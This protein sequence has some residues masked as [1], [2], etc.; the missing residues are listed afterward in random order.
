MQ[1]PGREAHGHQAGSP[2]AGHLH[3]AEDL[4]VPGEGFVLQRREVGG[5]VRVQSRRSVALQP[6]WRV[7]GLALSATWKEAV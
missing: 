6:L 3:P 5:G 7:T 4:K 2:G 1:G